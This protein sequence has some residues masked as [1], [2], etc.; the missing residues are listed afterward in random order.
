MSQDE[1]LPHSRE[2]AAAHHVTGRCQQPHKHHAELSS[3][4]KV[5]RNHHPDDD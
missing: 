5:C 4:P 1:L 3:T 2:F